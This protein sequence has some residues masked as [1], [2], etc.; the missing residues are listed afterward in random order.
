M[1]QCKSFTTFRPYKET[2]SRM[3]RF[4]LAL[5]LAASIG[6]LANASVFAAPGQVNSVNNGKDITAGTYYNTSGSKTVF[7][8][9]GTGGLKLKSGDLVRGL[10]SDAVGNP[11]GHGGHLHFNAPG[12]V[13][14]LDGNINVS[15]LQS[16]GAYTGNGGRVT[17]DAAYL[18]QNGS[19]FANGINGGHI[20]F[21]VGDAHF[22]S[23]SRL[24]AM[25]FG[26]HGGTIRINA[27]NK[28]T[29][30]EGAVMDA[31]G[32]VIGTYDTSIISIE[33]S[34][35]NNEGIQRAANVF[36]TPGTGSTTLEEESQPSVI[37]SD[38]T[39][40]NESSPNETEDETLEV[41]NEPQ[42]ETNEPAPDTPELA[43]APETP[44]TPD[45]PEQ[46]ESPEQAEAPEE[47]SETPEQAEAPEETPETPEQAEAPEEELLEQPEEVA[48][49]P[50]PVEEEV[51]ETPPEEVVNTGGNVVIGGENPPSE[52]PG[53]VIVGGGE[54]PP[55]DVVV[56]GGVTDT[57]TPEVVILPPSSP[58]TPKI[59]SPPGLFQENRPKPFIFTPVDTVSCPITVSGNVFPNSGSLAALGSGICGIPVTTSV[60]HI[61]LI[62]PPPVIPLAEHPV[63]N[64]LPPEVVER[65]TMVAP[66][67]P[68][69]IEHRPTVRGF[70]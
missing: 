15:A 18:Y 27:T 66:P 41:A 42:E 7:Q 9:T 55:G 58:P 70:W 22:N 64:P 56:G 26:G 32:D 38:S 52:P 40:Q 31:T 11:S 16:G 14:R 3:A 69:T 19:I 25:G 63:A 20:Q 1:R 29:V 5:S 39:I 46:S 67:P 68:R 13:V 10:E 35:V 54:S 6:I 62:P 4:G 43:E 12:A 49:A 44:D 36:I 33:G 47:T 65:P 21:N 34:I 28:V 24:E 45:A 59:D 57:I 2:N 51:V 53:E 30:Q 23:E 50:E 61:A 60:P 8:N 48:E 17:V 37:V